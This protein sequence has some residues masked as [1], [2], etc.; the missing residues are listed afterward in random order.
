MA[1]SS[2][3]NSILWARGL[4][5]A[6][7]QVPVLRNLTVGIYDGEAT[8]ITGARGGGKSTL[9]HCL[10]GILRPDS[11]EVWFNSRPLHTLPDKARA[12]L[13]QQW[14]GLV[15]PEGQ[16]VA[17][18]TAAEN[19]ALPLLFP[20]RDRSGAFSEAKAWLERL[21]A[22]DC[23]E[24]RADQLTRDQTQ[25]VAIARALV[26]SPRVIFADNLSEGLCG[27]EVDSILRLL[28]A[29]IRSLGTTLLLTTCDPRVTAYTDRELILR[30]GQMTSTGNQAWL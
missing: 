1:R 11:G 14:F 5:K 2:A 8:A 24:L 28:L 4:T 27:R 15:F 19:V 18:L 12:R 16:L 13:R 22:L 9:L 21:D 3:D 23:A 10:A 26:T 6:F 25:R 30:N 7:G 17:E 29:I 20:G